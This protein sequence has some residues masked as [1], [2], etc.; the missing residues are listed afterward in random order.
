MFEL[1]KLSS[2]KSAELADLGRAAFFD[3]VEVV[4]GAV[5]EAGVALANAHPVGATT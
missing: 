3:G 1:G 4:N 5:H 2:G